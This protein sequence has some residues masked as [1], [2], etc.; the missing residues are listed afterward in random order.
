[1]LSGHLSEHQAVRILGLRVSHDMQNTINR[2]MHPGN[3]LITIAL[4][5][6]DKPLI[7]TGALK[8]AITFEVL[9]RVTAGM[10]SAGTVLNG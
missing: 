8:Q 7:D 2:G 6:R 3:S 5:G 10:R 1:M 4:K 9:D